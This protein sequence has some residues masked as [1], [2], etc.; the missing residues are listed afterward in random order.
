MALKAVK[1][2][3]LQKIWNGLKKDSTQEMYNGMLSET[4]SNEL[5]LVTWRPS[6]LT[7]IY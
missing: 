4:D 3:L 2:D 7:Y 6:V 5:L 1:H